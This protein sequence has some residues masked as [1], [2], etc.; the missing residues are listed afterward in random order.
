VSFLNAQS[1]IDKYSQAW[2]D[3]PQHAGQVLPGWT[4]S[5]GGSYDDACKSFGAGSVPVGSDP[6]VVTADPSDHNVKGVK[7]AC[8]R[9][10]KYQ[11]LVYAA[12]TGTVAAALFSGFAYYKGYLS[13][14]QPQ[15]EREARRNRRHR[16][17]SVVVTPSLSPNLVGAGLSIEF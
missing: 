16:G 6:D 9:G 10:D 3:D 8:S 13:P 5:N 7:D 11:K 1:D 4:S 14:G 15:T 12:I 2:M 17:T